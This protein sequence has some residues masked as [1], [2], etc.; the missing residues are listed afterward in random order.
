[1]NS[2]WMSLLQ[3]VVK[4]LIGAFNYEKVVDLVKDM[5]RTDLSGSEK[6]QRVLSECKNIAFVIGTAL[7]NLA[8]E[9]AVVAMRNKK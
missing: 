8:I 2:I 3:T 6:R 5:E 4:A 7:L 9:T 1:M